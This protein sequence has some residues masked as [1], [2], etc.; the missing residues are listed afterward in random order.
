[1]NINSLAELWKAVCEESSC[2]SFLKKI[3]NIFIISKQNDSR[4]AKL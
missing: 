4:K 1:M 3:H 2:P